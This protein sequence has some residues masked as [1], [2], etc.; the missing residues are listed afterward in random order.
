MTISQMTSLVK[1]LK[2]VVK[3]RVLVRIAVVR[4]KKAQ[5]PTG[6]GLR[7]RPAM[8][9]R[10]IESN[11]HACEVTSRGFGIKNRTIKPIEM[12]RI[13]GRSLAPGA[14]G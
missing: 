10:K 3:V 9:E 5:A 4:P 11:C 13:K 6:K 12:E 14:W 8:V 7:T 2:A 1:A